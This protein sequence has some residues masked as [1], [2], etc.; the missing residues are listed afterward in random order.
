MVA[1]GRGRGVRTPTPGPYHHRTYY[2][3]TLSERGVDLNHPQQSVLLSPIYEPA[4]KAA[5]SVALRR[6]VRAGLDTLLRV[7]PNGERSYVPYTRNM[8]RFT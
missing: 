3:H 6:L 4:E 7:D 2:G 5:I 1:I 8:H